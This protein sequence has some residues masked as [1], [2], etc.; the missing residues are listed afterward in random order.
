MRGTARTTLLTEMGSEE[1]GRKGQSRTVCERDQE[2]RLCVNAVF[3]CSSHPQNYGVYVEPPSELHRPRLVAKLNKA[4]YGTQDASSAWQ[5]LWSEHT[6]SN[7]FEL[8]ASNPAL[9]RSEL[10]NGLCHGDDL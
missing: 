10:V 8:G 3:T 7:G 1:Q 2:S 9:C 6:R 5:K 4:M